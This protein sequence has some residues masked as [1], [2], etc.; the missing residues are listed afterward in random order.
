MSFF[1][2]IFILAHFSFQQ[3]PTGPE[4]L[5]KKYFNIIEAP[6]IW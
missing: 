2:E 5:K 1:L 6:L 4:N 3:K